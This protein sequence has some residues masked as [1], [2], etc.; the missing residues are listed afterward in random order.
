M[1]LLFSLVNRNGTIVP[2]RCWGSRPIWYYYS[3]VSGSPKC[4]YCSHLVRELHIWVL[5]PSQTPGPVCQCM[6]QGD[7]QPPQLVRTCPDI[8]QNSTW[9]N[10]S[11]RPDSSLVC[12]GSNQTV[13]LSVLVYCKV[14]LGHRIL[15]NTG[16]MG[17]GK[18]NSVIDKQL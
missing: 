3:H 8:K 1:I 16:V 18:D 7:S 9:S 4:Y 17:I 12:I 5:Y 14:G 2:I 11:C 6:H 10:P 13:L 15:L